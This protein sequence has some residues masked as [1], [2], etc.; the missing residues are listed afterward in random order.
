[1]SA[2]YMVGALPS[3][4]LLRSAPAS[5]RVRGG[6]GGRGRLAGEVLGR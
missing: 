6:G 4:V 2:N 3:M 5:Q 1:M